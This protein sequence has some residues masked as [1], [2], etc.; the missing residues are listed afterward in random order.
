MSRECSSLDRG[1]D[2]AAGGNDAVEIEVARVLEAYLA[3]VEAGQPADPHR[4]LDDYPQLATQLRACLRVLPRARAG[5]A[6]E[7][8]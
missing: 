2:A 4:L 5:H 7:N 1:P 8:P 3:A 6:S